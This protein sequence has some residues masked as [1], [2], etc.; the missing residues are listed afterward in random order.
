MKYFAL[1]ALIAVTSAVKFD[2]L[3]SPDHPNS[4]KVFS[5]NERAP[6]AAGLIQTSAC[7]NVNLPGVTCVPNSQLFAVGMNGDEDLNQTITMK[8]QKFSYNQRNFAEG[9]K[10]NED[11][12]E[13]IRIKDQEL[14]YP[15]RP[16]G[17]KLFAVGM[18]GDED[19][20]QTIT[21][22]GQKFQYAQGH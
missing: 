19:L 21:M 22:K 11:L 15:K 13:T 9:M 1:A 17:Q 12:G 14:R 16:V 18:N 3:D 6:S 4:S 8:G 7:M 10:G 2:S 5:Y 20:G